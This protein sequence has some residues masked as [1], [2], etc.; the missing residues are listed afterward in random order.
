MQVPLS[1][2]QAKLVEDLKYLNKQL[3]N[4]SGK[5]I[6]VGRTLKKFSSMYDGINV[7]P[8]CYI[9]S[10]FGYVT[11]PKEAASI[12]RAQEYNRK[13]IKNFDVKNDSGRIVKKCTYDS[14]KKR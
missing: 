4:K 6:D 9:K 8:I 1:F 10:S 11:D 3:S 14:Y 5:M 2:N 12:R 13:Y 7:K